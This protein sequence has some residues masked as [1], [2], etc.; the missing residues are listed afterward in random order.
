MI[1]IHVLVIIYCILQKILSVNFQKT[2]HHHSQ[3]PQRAL[4]NHLI[5]KVENYECNNPLFHFWA[6]F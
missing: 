6:I 1:N 3:G 5:V 4:R 2:H